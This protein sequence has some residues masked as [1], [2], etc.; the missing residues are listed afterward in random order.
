MRSAWPQC[1]MSVC[2]ADNVMQ[3]KLLEMQISPTIRLGDGW[4]EL[5]LWNSCKRARESSDV[6]EARFVHLL[7]V[8]AFCETFSMAVEIH[9]LIFSHH[10]CIQI[11]T[12]CNYYTSSAPMHQ[13]TSC[14]FLV[15]VSFRPCR[16]K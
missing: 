16:G 1:P 10:L 3:L 9:I 15:R 12:L 2:N 11:F 8:V 13:C 7:L 14:Q 6:S 4:A 5:V